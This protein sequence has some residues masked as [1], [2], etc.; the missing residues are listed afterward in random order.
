MS[1]QND[2]TQLRKLIR[3]IVL[4]RQEQD[5]QLR[6][7][8]MWADLMEQLTPLGVTPDMIESF[9]FGKCLFSL[10]DPDRYKAIKLK[11]GR[12]IELNPPVQTAESRCLDKLA[13]EQE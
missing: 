13:E 1:D 6:A 7:L 4:L 5:E 3:N 8:L 11:D 10:K 12:V 9:S 2:R